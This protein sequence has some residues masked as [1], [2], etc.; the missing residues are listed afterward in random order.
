MKTPSASSTAARNR[1]VGQRRTDT[2]AELSLRRELH[3]RGMR[4][5]VNF[6]V[7]DRRRRHDI[8]FPRERLV[9]EVYG[10][11]WH[12]CAEHGTSPKANAQWWSTKLAANR[13]RDIDTARRLAEVGWHLIT[14]WEHEDPVSAADRVQALRAALATQ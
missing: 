13:A 4:Y 14:V 11:Y 1:M 6:S 7:F 8:V 2:E 10:C 3:R 5:R 12:A 9:V